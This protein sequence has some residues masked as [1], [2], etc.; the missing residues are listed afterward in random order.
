V[1]PSWA[2]NFRC[3]GWGFYPNFTKLFFSLS[4]EI[5]FF[6]NSF[7]VEAVNSIGT[8][9]KLK[10]V[11]SSSFLSAIFFEKIFYQIFF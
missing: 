9:V 11:V 7:F 1:S 4:Y 6:E 3:V 2:S 5:G 8:Q 10:I